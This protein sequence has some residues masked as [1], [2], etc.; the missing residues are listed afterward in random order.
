MGLWDKAKEA[1][2][3]AAYTQEYDEED[4][5]QV[6]EDMKHEVKPTSL[7]RK[8]MGAAPLDRLDD[9]EKLE[10]L[11]T[12]FDLDIDDNDEGSNSQLLVTDK[13]A[14]ML[15]HSI[16]G[17]NSEYSVSFSDVIGVS[18]QRRFL[19]Q[20]RIETAGHSYK[21]SASGSKPELANEVAEYIRHASEDVNSTD[22]RV[23]SEEGP[24]DK[25][26]RLADLRNRGAV[27]DE[28][29]EEKKQQLMGEI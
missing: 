12:G 28:E 27:T 6:A 2:E 23:E 10:Y 3:A 24:L 5:K 15:A 29:F 7:R 26:E 11:L 21:I 18:V 19:A 9:G 16:T 22:P 4:A 14:I 8:R 25:L 13:R 17:K 20:I 1:A